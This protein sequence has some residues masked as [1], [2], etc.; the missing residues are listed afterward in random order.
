VRAVLDSLAEVYVTRDPAVM[1]ALFAPDP[2]VVMFT[3]GAD[4]VVGLAAIVA[5]AER[6]WSRSEAA[7]LTY[8]WMSI[9]SAGPMAWVAT[10]ADFSVTAGGQQMSIPA[11]ITFVLERRGERWLIQQAHYSFMTAAPSA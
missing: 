3:P 9:S 5:K 4:A 2:D 1:R 6:D 7:S 10:D 8:A 11:H